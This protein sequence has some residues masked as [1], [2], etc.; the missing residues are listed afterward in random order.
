MARAVL[1]AV[2]RLDQQVAARREVA[3][4]PV[5]LRQRGLL[6]LPTFRQARIAAGEGSRGGLI[7][8]GAPAGRGRRIAHP[9]RSLG[10]TSVARRPFCDAGGSRC[11]LAK[12]RTGGEDGAR[13]RI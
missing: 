1:D 11:G 8:G 3:Q 10:E 4:Q 13:G 5:D 7:H 6:D 12:G 2:Q 9:P